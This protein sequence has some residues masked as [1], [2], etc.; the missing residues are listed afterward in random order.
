MM[1]G[2]D[3]ERGADVPSSYGP[4]VADAEVLPELLVTIHKDTV[5]TQ[6]LGVLG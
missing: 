3:R 1:A 2:E 5:P 6:L 4:Q